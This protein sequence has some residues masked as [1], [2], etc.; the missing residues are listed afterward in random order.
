MSVGAAWED[1]W[2]LAMKGPGRADAL[3]G[4]RR[5][6]LDREGEQRL[7]GRARRGR[8]AGVFCGSLVWGWVRRPVGSGFD[9]LVD[10]GARKVLVACPVAASAVYV[11]DLDAGLAARRDLHGDDK[12]EAG[13][14]RDDDAACPHGP[15]VAGR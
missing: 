4:L 14:K 5:V 12:D 1:S 8:L 3:A 15:S 9:G 11:G 13:R 6:A 7:A 2:L 10:D